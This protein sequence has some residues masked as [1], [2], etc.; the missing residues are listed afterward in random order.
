MKLFLTLSTVLIFFGH[1]YCQKTVNRNEQ[2]WLQ[3]YNQIKLSD[4]FS[5]LSD[6]GVRTKTGVSNW[7]Q[8][9]SRISLNYNINKNIQGVSGF[10][11]FTTFKEN[12][13][14]TIELRPYKEFNITN[15][16]DK[17]KIQNRLRLEYRNF[18]TYGISSN[19]F[20]LRYRLFC[21]YPLM[22][23]SKNK[24]DSKL[25][26]YFGDEL[27]INFGKSIIYNTLDN[28]R[29][30]LGLGFQLNN[31]LTCSITYNYQYGRRGKQLYEHSDILW[32]T[33]NHKIGFKN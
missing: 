22:S 9:T 26:L 20:R 11:L 16:I 21:T 4:K 30:L 5:L 1:P 15:Q 33:V 31:A 27:F 8:I 23:L 18:S 29:L 28:N 17:I 32:I 13:A 6:F 25:L 10:A 12:I 2:L 3:Y 7:Y 19:N 14:S 24:P